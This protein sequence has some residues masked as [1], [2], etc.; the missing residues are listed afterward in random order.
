[1]DST[2]AK[3]LKILEV[4][5]DSD[6]PQGVT[7]LA[8][9][10]GLP[11]SNIHRTL[12]TLVEIGYATRHEDLHRYSATLKTWEVGANIISRNFLRRASLPFLRVLH[13]MSQE[14]V[15]LAVLDGTD[16]LYLEK[17]DALYPMVKSARIGQ[18]MPSIFPASGLALLAHMPDAENRVRRCAE[19]TADIRQSDPDA[20]LSTLAQVRSQ[21]YARTTSG[22]NQGTL[23]IAVPIL[24]P[25]T[26]T[27]G[28][29]GIAG[30]AE[31]LT[32]ELVSEWIPTL[33]NSAMQISELVGNEGDAF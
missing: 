1:M 15:Y 23:S 12:S 8:Q 28:A 10:L 9:R 11:K 31:R 16:V 17:L 13:Q 2:L 30:A 14:T 3:G 6:R 7:A 18:R 26:D 27:M 25:D 24:R 22:W 32:E 19:A 20:I 5:A 4:L 29:I 33:R 21:G